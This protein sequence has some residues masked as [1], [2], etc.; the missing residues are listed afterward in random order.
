MNQTAHFITDKNFLKAVQDHLKI[1]H[2]PTFEEVAS[3]DV[4]LADNYEIKS[5]EGAQYF[6]SAIELDFHDNQIS[7]LTPLAS[8]TQLQRL[9]LGNNPIED[10]TPLANLM[11]L[12]RLAI[13]FNYKTDS[14]EP[15]AKLVNLKQL[16][17]CSNQLT[18]IRPLKALTKL[19]WVKLCNNKITDLSVLKELPHLKFADVS[20]N[21]FNPEEI[22]NK[23]TILHLQKQGSYK[24]NEDFFVASVSKR[25]V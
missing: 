25:L 21:A 17:V 3:I 10:I 8:L 4:L 13:G 24:N 16:F 19:E 11:N 2:L 20:C 23:E 7:D 9:E 15:L 18:D 6:T 14:L 22:K 5:I 1:E 12:Y